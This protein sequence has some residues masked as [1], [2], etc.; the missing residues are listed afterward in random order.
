MS[1]LSKYKFLII[2]L[3]LLIY[4]LSTFNLVEV[5]IME[6]RNFQSANE[7]INNKNWLFPTL[8][9]EPRYQKPPLP[10]WLTALSVL[11]FNSKSIIF[12]RIPAIIFLLII[13]VTNYFFSL[14]IGFKKNESIINGLITLSSIYIIAI[15]FEA[16][17]DIFTHGFMLIAI[18]YLYQ[19]LQTKFITKTNFIIGL[20][21]GLSI[22]SKGPISIYVLL[23][24]FILSFIMVYKK[25]NTNGIIQ[26]ILVAIISGC[27]WYAYI[28][29]FDEKT[30]LNTGL[31]ET[32]NWFNYNIKP[33]YYYWNFFI[34]SG[35]WAI[36]AITSII[37]PFT[38]IIK[39]I[40]KNHLLTT[41][42]VILSLIFLS[43]V[44]EKKTRY[45]MPVLIPLALNTGFYIKY[46]IT[47]SKEK[48][49][50]SYIPIYIN[51]IL[52]SIAGI[53]I[54]SIHIYNYGIDIFS[55]I[56]IFI[57]LYIIISLYKQ[58]FEK[59][60]YL[61]VILFFCAINFAIPEIYSNKN[62]SYTK[63]DKIKQETDQL[64]FYSDYK[65]SPV[66]VWNLNTIV[67]EIELTNINDSTFVFISNL[68]SDS[69]KIKFRN[70]KI[71]IMEKIKLDFNKTTK[72][73]R[74]YR[75]R[76]KINLYILS[77][78]RAKL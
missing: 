17:W 77:K 41:Y 64:R 19:S 46:I 36:P 28:Y 20:M 32:K 50:K 76:L 33:F 10:T 63:I 9:G 60:I 8:N 71:S 75:D 13:S 14:K 49:K 1:F 31:K 57:G 34:N 55:L 54:P 65:I 39:P 58:K 27:A 62:K 2:L 3:I 26:I 70:N 52:I 4:T 44:P 73:N 7:M 12:Y 6:A 38:N 25:F 74:R 24:P 48:I 21:I 40:N 5:G 30:L 47:F 69:L 29:I 23:I 22:M 35:I 61:K 51:F 15:I 53:I 42:W 43:I 18:Y 45:L 16:P 59:I 78:I 37:L 67:E 72:E 66:L 68:N 11:I 56:S